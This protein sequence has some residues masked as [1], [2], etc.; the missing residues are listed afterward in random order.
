MSGEWTLTRRDFIK[1]GGVLAASVVVPSALGAP[2]VGTDTTLDPSSLM[3][4]LEIHA[5]GSIIARTGK[6]ETGTSASAFYAQV[7]AEEL[8]VPAASVSLIMG[9]TDETPDGGF[10]AGFLY[11]VTNLKKVAAYTRQALMRLAAAK[12]DVPEEKL[13]VKDGVMSGEGAQVGYGDLVKG[14]Q[15]DLTISVDGAMP[16]IDPTSAVGMAGLLGISVMEDPPTKAVANYK[17]V[18]TSYGRPG[19]RDVVMGKPVYSGDVVL[20]GM[21]HARMVRPSTLGSTL[22]SIG[23]LD[24]SRFPTAEV[25]VK[26]SFVAVVSPNEWEAVQAARIVART[27]RWTSWSGLPS[28]DN[29]TEV[30]RAA[31]WTLVGRKGEPAKVNAALASA[32]RIVSAT[33]EGPYVRCA[34]IGAYVAVADVSADGMVTIWAQ[35]AHPQGARAN[36]ANTLGVPFDN[37]TIRWAEGAGQYGRTTLGGDGAMADAAILSQLLG[38]P[39]RVEWTIAEDLT[40]SSVSPPWY[41]E[42]QVGLDPRGNMVAFKSDW[43]AGHEN[44]ARMLGAIL[45]GMPTLTPGPAQAYGAALATVWPYDKTPALEQA[46]FTDNIANTA[47]A[48]GLRGNMMRTPQQR[49]QNVALE[50]IITE[51]A[52]AAG[53]DQV[54]FR[55]RHTTDTAFAG[56][57]KAVA[58]AHGWEPRPSPN[59]AAGRAGSTPVAGRGVGVVLRSGAPW[60]AMADVEITP[61]TG[62]VRLTAFTVGIDVGKVMNPRHLKSM[63][64]G[65]VVMGI[66]EALFEEVTFDRS[67]VT[68]DNWNRY[69]IPHMKDIPD[70]K[71]VFMSRDDRGIHGGGEA[72]NAVAPPAIMAAFFDATGVMPRR[73]PLK[74]E[75]VLS[76]L[77][78][79]DKVDAV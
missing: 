37:V 42:V 45:A 27:T 11:G 4:W 69:R 16:T 49:Q 21:W 33:Y 19:I 38:K 26:E 9:H 22:Q 68:S 2:R 66:G 67:K 17:V 63:L 12:L 24:R 78:S 52:A 48:G 36:I 76:L 75:Y 15:L 13:T 61:S 60:V 77:A 18:G 3:S 51:A 79:V 46:F 5:D 74:R 30:L 65:G 29:L 72:A 34:P 62:G 14:Q 20:P 1:V 31:E 40:W 23:T 41:A 64:E 10:S 54:E 47:A 70:I 6:T 50:G 73:T 39:V 25:V 56:V 8:D 59:P 32:T 55:L 71:T 35:S 44:D 57:L 7:I 58:E 53:T 28:T 43:Y